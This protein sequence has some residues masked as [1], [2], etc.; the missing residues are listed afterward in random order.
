MQLRILLPVLLLAT[1][2]FAC[3]NKGKKLEI[4]EITISDTV[5]EEE[6]D[7]PQFRRNYPFDN[8]KDWFSYLC[9][10]IKPTNEVVAYYFSINKFNHNYSVLFTGN[11]KYDPNDKEWIYHVVNSVQDS[12][13]L[14]PDYQGLSDDEVLKMFAS[15][16]RAFTRTQ[17]FEQSHFAKAKAIGTGFFQEKIV[18]IK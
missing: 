12:N 6:P 17:Q 7:L 10:S 4:K 16:L 3:D 9:D 5:S 1:L 2:F 11:S 18:M 15:E 8:L 14:P 13:P